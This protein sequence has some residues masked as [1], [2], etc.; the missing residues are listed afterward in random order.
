MLDAD[1]TF[2]GDRATTRPE[3]EAEPAAIGSH[4]VTELDAL[5]Q[6]LPEDPDHPPLVTEVPAPESQR[7]AIEHDVVGAG[8]M[9]E[10]LT[11]LETG[12]NGLANVAQA[13]ADLERRAVDTSMDLD[14]RVGEFE[15]QRQRIEQALSEATRLIDA[16]TSLEQ[17]LSRLSDSQTL[18]GRQASRSRPW[19]LLQGIRKAMSAPRT[20]LATWAW[21]RARGRAVGLEV[22]VM[23]LIAVALALTR[24]V[25]R[26]QD[27]TVRATTDSLGSIASEPPL[28]RDREADAPPP[29]ALEPSREQE[30]EKPDAPARPFTGDL[31]IESEPRHATVFVDQ[32]HIGETP[33]H[34]KAF[35]AGSHAIRIDRDGYERWT[36]GVL[37]AAEQRTRVSAKLDRSRDR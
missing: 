15:S 10:L 7:Q 30:A 18:E 26:P 27:A 13:V 1:P 32:R 21:V 36:A 17:R 20:V 22:G 35:R 4:I 33:V 2:S 23:V 28:V 25:P 5:A 19:V 34:L 8:R 3:D 12:I 24:H 6:F 14:Q 31:T 9:A 16:L 11:A 37:V 29:T